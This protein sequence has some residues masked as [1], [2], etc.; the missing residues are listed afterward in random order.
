MNTG[1]TTYIFVL[2]GYVSPECVAGF[3][4]HNNFALN[5]KAFAEVIM[6]HAF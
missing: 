4:L 2:N 1:G 6:F 5:F 3:Q